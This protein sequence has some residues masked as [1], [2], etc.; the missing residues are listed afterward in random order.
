LKG[1]TYFLY[2]AASLPRNII[3]AHSV[4][5]HEKKCLINGSHNAM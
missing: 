3:G 2:L 5:M 4:S 1:A